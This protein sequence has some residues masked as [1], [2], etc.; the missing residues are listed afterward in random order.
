M[1]V[2]KRFDT[3]EV[4]LNYTEGPNNGPPLVL[5]HGF[6][7]KWQSFT[8]LLP[9]LLPRWHIYALDHRGHGKSTRKPGYYRFRDYYRDTEKFI[10]EQVEEKPV[11]LTHRLGG[12]MGIM[13]AANHPMNTRALLLLDPPMNFNYSMLN[14]VNQRHNVWV[15]VRMG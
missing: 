3:G 1:L 13:Y 12:V 11:I 6:T 15:R 8:S 9:Q 2:E 14:Y 10:Q 7:G 4:V 5:L